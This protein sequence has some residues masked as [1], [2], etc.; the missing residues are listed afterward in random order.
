[1][2]ERCAF[3]CHKRSIVIDGKMLA[4]CERI[5]TVQ[6]I[7][8]REGAPLFVAND[9]ERHDRPSREQPKFACLSIY[10]RLN[11]RFYI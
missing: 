3:S 11:K 4:E 5:L 1:M 9:R 6:R 2:Q 8:G 7:S 10:L